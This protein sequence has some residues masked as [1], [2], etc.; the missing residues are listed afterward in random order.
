MRAVPSRC[1]CQETADSR[2]VSARLAILDN[3]GEAGSNHFQSRRVELTHS[4]LPSDRGFPTRRRDFA[5]LP[6]RTANH[7]LGSAAPARP[8]EW[9]TATRLKDTPNWTWH[10]P[11]SMA[12]TLSDT[13][14]A[15][16]AT[17]VRLWWQAPKGSSVD[18]QPVNRLGDP[19]ACRN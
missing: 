17:R 7:R 6:A 16:R 12:R 2:Q 8:V 4:E 9:S 18:Q 1:L 10:S 19:D 14:S 3:A 5:V 13:A 15:A 11:P